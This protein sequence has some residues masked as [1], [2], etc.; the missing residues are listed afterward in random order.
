MREGC[1]SF[2]NDLWPLAEMLRGMCLKLDVFRVTHGYC[3]EMQKG[4]CYCTIGIVNNEN[5]LFSI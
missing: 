2:P 4:Q 5:N 3:R 1:S